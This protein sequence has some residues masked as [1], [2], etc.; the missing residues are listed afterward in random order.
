MT[1][2]EM[3]VPC[4]V[5][6]GLLGIIGLAASWLLG[7]VAC[8]KSSFSASLY[9]GFIWATVPVLL[10]MLSYISTF[11]LG[12]FQE[13]VKYLAPNISPEWTDVCARAIIMVLAGIPMTA[14][15][16]HTTDI[17]VCKPSADELKKFQ[18]DLMKEL[19]AKEEEKPTQ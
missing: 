8:N 14:R 1:I 15:M 18:D 13:P 4:G 19:K 9:E 7:L 10:L 2:T 3:L 16:L 11:F 17:A 12:I 5:S 6:Y